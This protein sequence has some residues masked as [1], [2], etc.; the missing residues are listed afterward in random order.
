MT[1]FATIELVLAANGP[2]L[3]AMMLCVWNIRWYFSVSVG[4]RIF[5]APDQRLHIYLH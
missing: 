1:V 3:G 4:I 2:R 5:I